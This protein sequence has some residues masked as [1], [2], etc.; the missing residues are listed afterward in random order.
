MKIKH[1]SSRST[2]GRGRGCHN[3]PV[4]GGNGTKIAP[5]ED[6]FDQSPGEMS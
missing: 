2:I 4:L 1:P 6:L 3:V 5:P